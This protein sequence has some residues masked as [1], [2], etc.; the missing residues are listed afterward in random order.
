MPEEDGFIGRLGC[1]NPEL[2]E[3]HNNE[4]FSNEVLNS[5][6]CDENRD[7]QTERRMCRK[8][9]RKIDGRMRWN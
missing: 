6:E 9:R 4:A 7:L 8:E 3:L 5:Y 2:W 1:N